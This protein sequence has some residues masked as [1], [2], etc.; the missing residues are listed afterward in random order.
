[1]RSVRDVLLRLENG[2]A[3]GCA[4][5]VAQLAELFQCVGTLPQFLSVLEADAV[6]DEVRMRMGRVAVGGDQNLVARPGLCRDLQRDLVRPGV[7]D[8]LLRGEGLDVLI[9]IDPVG[10]APALLGQKKF[11]QSVVTGAVDAGEIPAAFPATVFSSWE[12]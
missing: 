7:G 9:E 5:L 2:K 4:E 1:M 10:F 11:R 8:A 6:D 3:V 12:Q